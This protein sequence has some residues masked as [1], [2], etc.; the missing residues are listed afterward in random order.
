[1]SAY[2]SV[3][4]SCTHTDVAAVQWTQHRQASMKMAESTSV[5][6]LRFHAAART[7]SDKQ[8]VVTGWKSLIILW[9]GEKQEK[10]GHA[11]DSLAVRLGCRNRW[12]LLTYALQGDDLLVWTGTTEKC[13]RK[14]NMS[15]NVSANNCTPYCSS[16]YHIDRFE[17]FHNKLRLAGS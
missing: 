5:T 13:H 16:S 15:A 7:C 2:G 11:V 9:Y 6:Q 4:V 1:M 17:R 12:R 8:Y 3:Q 10:A 14:K